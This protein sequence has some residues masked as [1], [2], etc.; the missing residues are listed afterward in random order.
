MTEKVYH[1]DAYCRE[2]ITPVSGR[3]YR[4]GRY[5]IRCERTIFCPEGGGQ[6]ADQGT[7]SGLPLLALEIDGDDIVHVLGQDP[8]GGEACLR[9]D[10][11][12]RYDH[13]QQHTSQ[14]LL[15]QALVRLF[16]I[17]TLSFAIGAEHSSIEIDRTVFSEEETKTL[18]A[19]CMRLVL[20]GLPVHIFESDDPSTLHLRKPPKV[21]GRI[22]VVEIDGFDQS[23]CGGTHLK[24]SAEIGLLKIVRTERVRANTRLYYAVG[25]RAL[26]DYQLKH[27]V[28]LRLQRMITLP[29]AGIPPQ[30]ETLIRERD[31]LRRTL[32]KAQRREMEK[33]AAAAPAGK[34]SLVVREFSGLDP[35]D[36]RS[37][38]TA[39]IQGGKNVLAFQRSEPA[40]VIIGRSRGEFDLRRISSRVFA[41]L[42]GNGGG[43]ANLVEGRAS[44]FSRMAEVISLLQASFAETDQ[45]PDA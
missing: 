15:S 12:R 27:A 41:L 32:K 9:L 16:G 8:G 18:E 17:A 34:D 28:A 11:D 29:L 14:H 22:R 40:H 20:A 13:M 45:T 33:E 3:E 1:R 19:E 43:S 42:N 23:A 10:F 25:Y 39:L 7:V 35:V 44:D 6:P 37:F 38:A 4:A 31:E 2:I 21:Q 24:S 36:L 30:V 5:H 26:R